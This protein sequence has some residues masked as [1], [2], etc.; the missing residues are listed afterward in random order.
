LSDD[1]KFLAI[2]DT[3]LYRELEGLTYASEQSSLVEQN[4]LFGSFNSKE[5]QAQVIARNKAQVEWLKKR[6]PLE[7][8]IIIGGVV[9]FF[10]MFFGGLIQEN[11]IIEEG[12]A[13]SAIAEPVDLKDTA[14]H[15][16]IAETAKVQEFD[17]GSLP[18]YCFPD[19]QRLTLD[20]YNFC[21]K[22]GM[23]YVQVAN[24]VGN[25][26]TNYG[27]SGAVEV[28]NW[29]GTGVIETNPGI[30]SINFVDDRL[31]GKTQS[32]LS[33]CEPGNCKR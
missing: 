16:G 6:S 4:K 23:S 24:I 15:K 20:T 21:I 5:F 12:K 27:K 13:V 18:E 22:E 25:A 31:A 14:S 33:N 8:K 9:A 26:G 32:G 28:W 30:M 3:E 29:G 19:H 11:H 7:Q 10:L 2:V 1:S 17:L